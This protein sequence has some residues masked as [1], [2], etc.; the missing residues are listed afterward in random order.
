MIE[1]EHKKLSVRRQAALLGINRNRLP[2]DSGRAEPPP[3][4]DLAI[5]KNLDALAVLRAT[6]AAPGVA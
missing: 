6:Q 1:T 5:L 2:N 3:C 4:E